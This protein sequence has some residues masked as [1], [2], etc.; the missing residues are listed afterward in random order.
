MRRLRRSETLRRMVREVS[1]SVD[2]LICPLFV[3]HGL[4]VKLQ[5]PSMPG[6]F[7]FSVDALVKE[8]RELADLG[9]P[10]GA[11]V[12]AARGQGRC[13]LRGVFARG[14]RPEGRPHA[15][16]GGARSRC[17]HGRLPLRI[18]LAWPLRHRARRR[19]RQRRDPRSHRAHRA[20]ARSGGGGHRGAVGYDGRPRA[21]DPRHARRERLHRYDRSCPTRPSSPRRSTGRSGTRPAARR[22]SA[23]ARPI[24]WTRPTAARPCRRSRSTSTRARTS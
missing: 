12:R 4:D 2:D 23:T 22:S 19:G 18:H 6:V 20:L 14:D 1:V 17:D 11:A 24:R 5:I 13:R 3:T 15:Q 8:A 16:E 9:I 21:G 10:G 7:H